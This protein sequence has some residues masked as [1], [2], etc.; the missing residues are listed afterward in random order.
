MRQP[1]F[2]VATLTGSLLFGAS[3]AG[4]MRGTA[5][6]A[7]PAATAPAARV[8]QV[9]QVDIAPR[10]QA[11]ALAEAIRQQF[12]GHAV[13]VAFV[14]PLLAGGGPSQEEVQA[15]A[16]IR[17]DGSAPMTVRTAALYDREARSVDA[18]SLW[19]E[20]E[21]AQPATEPLRRA[22]AAATTQRLGAEFAG[23]PFAVALGDASA[24]RVGGRY[25]RVVAHG[26]TDFGTEGRAATTVQALYDPRNDE[27]LRLD[28]A[29][30]A[31]PV[32]LQAADEGFAYAAD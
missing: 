11:L 20:A 13:D 31:D 16:S 15:L 25:L 30:G 8:A 12:P 27:W 32:Q 9:A 4:A 28:Y 22:L 26:A 10:P 21:G 23:Q 14:A 6:P 1:A 18:P 17:I 2:I 19:F 3:V 29:L 5:L 24:A 7:V